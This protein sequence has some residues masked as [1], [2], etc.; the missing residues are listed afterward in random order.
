MK[1]W[2]IDPFYTF[3]FLSWKKTRDKGYFRYSILPVISEFVVLSIFFWF[4]RNLNVL[5]KAA[6]FLSVLSFV[7]FICIFTLFFRT[8]TW[9][10]KEYKYK[11]HTSKADNL[12]QI[13]KII[14]VLNIIRIVLGFSF[15][16]IIFFYMD[17]IIMLF[18]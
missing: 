7:L 13:D 17:K 9:L 11:V 18:N 6:S 16:L 4:F 2:K 8:L 14:S 10:W 1:P 5:P 15:F 12:K 3:N